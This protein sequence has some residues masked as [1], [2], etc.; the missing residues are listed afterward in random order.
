MKKILVTGGPV[1]A[2]LDSVKIITNRF[3]GGLMAATANKL[4]G[5]T[6]VEVHYLRSK[7][8]V[9][10]DIPSDQIHEHF[11]FHDYMEKVLQMAPDF[12]AVVL[13]AAVC[14]LIPVKPFEGKFPS[15][16]YKPGD[17]IPIDFTI[18]PRVIDEVKKVAP[19]THLFGY[20]LLVGVDHEE[21]VQ[22]AYD[23]VLESRATCVFANDA[24]DLNT[25]FAVTK[26]GAEH[27][28][29]FPQMPQFILDM[30][31]DKYYKTDLYY[32]DN[33]CRAMLLKYE[34]K[35]NSLI[36]SFRDKFIKKNGYVFGTVAVR[37]ENPNP[38]MI[39]FITTCRGKNEVKD[40]TIVFN[41][42]HEEKVVYSHEKKATLNAPLLAR[43]FEVN[44]RVKAIVHCHELDTG[45][46]V[47]PY[48]PPGTFRD[49]IHPIMR[50][51]KMLGS[52]FEIKNHGFFRLF[53]EI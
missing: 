1:H 35:V 30:V 3:K 9:I 18:A 25:K 51:P 14:N 41:V 33:H 48:A 5:L 45:L 16:N 53:E 20:K 11:G 2:H 28:L 4:N 12:D 50:D 29:L 31:N 21:L 44:P 27:K 46:P 17:V 23:I 40:F 22:A 8:S 15:H 42:N 38:N 13:G 34:A 10:P 32:D 26:E 49:S 36:S 7:G 24:D 39:S 37:V 52:S 6:D 47:L 43:I 19:N